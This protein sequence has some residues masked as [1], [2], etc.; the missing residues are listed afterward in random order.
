LLPGATTA[1]ITVYLT[2]TDNVV[3]PSSIV[4]APGVSLVHFTLEALSEGTGSITFSSL[5]YV[6]F[7]NNFVIKNPVCSA[8]ETVTIFSTFCVSCP[9]INGNICSNNGVCSY[10]TIDQYSARCVCNAGFA[11]AYCELTSPSPFAYQFTSAGVV[12]DYFGIPGVT[13][14]SFI[15]PPAIVQDGN[16]VD[17]GNG[18]VFIRGYDSYSPFPFAVNPDVIIP[19][20]ADFNLNPVPPGFGIDIT[21]SDNTIYDILLS[22]VTVTFQFDPFVISQTDFLELELFYYNIT[23]QKWVPAISTCPPSEQLLVENLLALTL[24]TNIC[25]LGQYQFY[26]LIP[27]PPY[28]PQAGPVYIYNNYQDGHQNEYQFPTTGGTGVQQP[29]PPQP[30]LAPVVEYDPSPPRLPFL[31]EQNNASSLSSYFVIPILLVL[32]LL[33]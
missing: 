27:I 28:A 2:S 19:S 16:P 23:S 11:G 21:F 9:S 4:F 6:S 25:V 14:A 5:G 3:V 10:S 15:V 33:F 7:T 1:P 20:V 24:E 12:I 22:P 32:S 30:H 29:L 8:S 31:N 26:A 13:E 17:G 18:T